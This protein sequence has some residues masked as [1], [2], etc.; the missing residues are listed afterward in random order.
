MIHKHFTGKSEELHTFLDQIH[1]VYNMCHSSLRQSLLMIIFNE[2]EGEPREKLREHP[3]ILTYQ[4]LRDFLKEHYDLK[5][6]FAQAYSNLAAVKQLPSE[7]VQK[8]GDRITNLAYKAKLASKKEKDLT[9]ESA[10]QMIQFMA[11]ERFKIGSK[12]EIS[13]FICCNPYATTL[14]EAITLAVEFETKEAQEH[15]NRSQRKYCSYCRTETHNTIDCRLKNRSK[16]TECSYCH[17]PGHTRDVCRKKHF[18]ELKKNPPTNA[19]ATLE[20]RYC[21]KS[22]H[23]IRDCCKL[24][25]KKKT[26]PEKYDRTHPNFKKTQASTSREN[27]SENTTEARRIAVLSSKPRPI[28]KFKSPSVKSNKLYVLL[29]SGAEASLIKNSCLTS[30]ARQKINKNHIESFAGLSDSRTTSLGKLPV[31]IH[32]GTRIYEIDF[33]VVNDPDLP[34]TF[35]GLIGS[36][37]FDQIQASIDYSSYNLH[38]GRWNEDISLHR[39]YQLAPQSRTIL[40]IETKPTELIEGIVE[41]PSDDPNIIIIPEINTITNNQ[42]QK[43]LVHLSF[44]HVQKLPTDGQILIKWI[45]TDKQ[46]GDF[47]TKA[48]KA[49]KFISFRNKLMCTYPN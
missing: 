36:N 11:L 34:T 7:T 21:K 48:L 13:R 2:I 12:T 19:I 3:E 20:C 27:Q 16:T 10:T 38:I 17:I 41:V 31:R 18:D 35:D 32:L 22:G 24:A 42:T 28:A 8:Y 25:Y 40:T 26:E 4:Q 9:L 5:E 37:I 44:H 6:S 45:G 43:H 29:D 39:E 14:T 15:G 46:L 33:H 30:T 1:N 23:E 49:P 47:F